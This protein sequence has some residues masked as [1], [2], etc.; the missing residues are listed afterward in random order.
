MRHTVQAGLGHLTLQPPP[1]K[2]YD[3]RPALLTPAKAVIEE[4]LSTVGGAQHVQSTF[5]Y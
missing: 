1:P 3:Y 2:R 5:V 4:F